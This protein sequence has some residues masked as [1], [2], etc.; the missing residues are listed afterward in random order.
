[1][2]V[3]AKFCYSTLFRSRPVSPPP[4]KR[5]RELFYFLCSEFTFSLTHAISNKFFFSSCCY[6]CC[7]LFSVDNNAQLYFS[8]C[9]SNWYTDFTLT[10]EQWASNQAINWSRKKEDT[11]RVSVS[12]ILFTF[13]CFDK[14][15]IAKEWIEEE[16]EREKE[17]KRDKEEKERESESANKWNNKKK[18]EQSPEN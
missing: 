15:H 7:F 2:L 9:V 13:S 12:T 8:V 16:N 6:C 18:T 4:K 17:T 11:D 14:I 5:R 10:R 1:M 3:C